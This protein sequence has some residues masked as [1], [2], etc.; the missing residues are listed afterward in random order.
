MQGTAD[1]TFAP[2]TNLSRAMVAATLYRMVHGGTAIEV[3][4][5][6]NRSVFTDV[7]VNAWYSH[8]VTWA[9][10]NEIVLG[11]GGNHFAPSAYVTREQFAAMMHR[12]AGFME[13]DTAVHEG[14]QWDSFA[15]R[16][17]ISTWDGAREALIWANYYEL[18]TGR[19]STTIVPDGTATRAEAAA[20]LTRLM[21]AFGD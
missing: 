2:G 17:Q 16:N 11:V 18:I 6:D 4:Y 19:T 9:Y 5:P 14:P 1:P 7:A 12:F 10:D 3:P 21:N 20:I 13:Y 15:D 8:Y